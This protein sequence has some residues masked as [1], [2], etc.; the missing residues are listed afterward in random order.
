MPQPI[1]FYVFRPLRT[2]LAQPCELPFGKLAGGGDA[3]F[4]QGGGVDFAV[5]MPPCLTVADGAHRGHVGREA[6]LLAQ[7]GKLVEQPVRQHFFETRRDA[8]VQRR[9]IRGNQR[10][11]DR[12]AGQR[13]LC[14]LGKSVRER[15]AGGEDDFQRPLDALR[16]IGGEPRGGGGVAAGEF[17]VQRGPALRF[18]AGVDVGA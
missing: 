16:V 2:E 5:Q 7:G 3:R 10:H 11:R 8:P 6:V 1:G 14:A 15:L 13:A 18:G 4:Q 9:P 17:G 12:A